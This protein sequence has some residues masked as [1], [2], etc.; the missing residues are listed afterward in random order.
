MENGKGRGGHGKR[1][2]LPGQRLKDRREGGER[3][4]AQ[5]FSGP[6]VTKGHWGQGGLHQPA[7]TGGTG[8]LRIGHC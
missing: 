4:F 6:S 5:A 3:R 7:T 8:F 1:W 2:E